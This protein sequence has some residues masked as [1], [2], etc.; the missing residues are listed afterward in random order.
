M[1][2]RRWCAPSCSTSVTNFEDGPLSTYSVASRVRCSTPTS[3]P[4][5]AQPNEDPARSQRDGGEWT[6]PGE[7][8]RPG[9]H[10]R[11]APSASGAML[12]CTTSARGSGHGK[13]GVRGEDRPRLAGFRAV[14]APGAHP[15]GGR[16]ERR[17]RRPRRRRVRPARLLRIRHR[18]PEDRRVGGRGDPPDQLP[19]HRALLAHPGLPAHRPKPP[20]QRHGS[21]RRPGH[22]FPRLLG[23]ATAGERLLVRNAAH[24]RL[25]HLRRRQVAPQS[26]GRDEHGRLARHVAA[27]ARLRPLVRIPRR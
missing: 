6:S 12:C 2:L 5:G 1:V 8:G 23:P 14:V 13:G 24:G 17:A 19:H 22:R 20:P 25:R 7:T 9:R 18:D 15:A 11:G 26:R 27:R 21:R 4:G 3:S 16:A 10:G